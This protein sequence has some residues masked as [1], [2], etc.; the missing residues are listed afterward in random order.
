[1]INRANQLD[2]YT[3]N[4]PQAHQSTPNVMASRVNSVYQ[5]S[6]QTSPEPKYIPKQPG[7]ASDFVN[8]IPTPATPPRQQTSTPATSSWKQISSAATPPRQQTSPTATSSW[9]QINSAAKT[10][11]QQTNPPAT[12]PRL[13]AASYLDDTPRGVRYVLPEAQVKYTFSPVSPA[14]PSNRVYLPADYSTHRIKMSQLRDQY[15]SLNSLLNQFGCTKQPM[16]SQLFFERFPG[17]TFK[18]EHTP[19]MR[20]MTKQLN[21]FYKARTAADVPFKNIM[22]TYQSYEKLIKL[23]YRDQQ[24]SQAGCELTQLETEVEKE[25]IQLN[26]SFKRF[27]FQLTSYLSGRP[28]NDTTQAFQIYSQMNHKYTYEVT[29]RNTAQTFAGMPLEYKHLIHNARAIKGTQ[30]INRVMEA[31]IKPNY[32]THKPGQKVMVSMEGLA[33]WIID[34]DR[35]FE[36]VTPEMKEAVL[37]VREKIGCWIDPITNVKSL[38]AYFRFH[39]PEL[40]G[41]GIPYPFME[42]M[43]LT[44]RMESLFRGLNDTTE[45]KIWMRE[46][47]RL[48]K[49]DQ[50]W[51]LN[52]KIILKEQ[53]VLIYALEFNV[54]AQVLQLAKELAQSVVHDIFAFELA[55][56]DNQ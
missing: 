47:R 39:H 52:A 35:Y 26:Q 31:F 45:L 5:S 15:M 19:L 11:S 42:R 41:N 40:T 49:V 55:S 8:Q 17:Y 18:K 23:G 10:S 44:P 36:Q 12:P 4:T 9:K 1:M 50:G 43:P 27:V 32:P 7:S 28:V 34:C 30:W 22:R 16:F 3:T 37:E 29:A 24:V 21:D 38:V 14:I 56:K 13:P 20:A 46:T 54:D 53:A 25:L 48:F 2:R 6:Y 51:D 33:Q